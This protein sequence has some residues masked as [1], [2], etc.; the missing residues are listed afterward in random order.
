MPYAHIRESHAA[1][2]Y[3]EIITGVL[4]TLPNKLSEMSTLQ[5]CLWHLCGD[6]WKA[7]PNDRPKMSSITLRLISISTDPLGV[8]LRT[9]NHLNVTGAIFLR[10]QIESAGGKFC[11]VFIGY[12]HRGSKFAKVAVKQLRSSTVVEGDRRAVGSLIILP[13]S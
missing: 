8:T 3:K 13:Q 6:C 1:S 11:D 10:K 7:I 12:V 4:P 5:A 2:L 9:L